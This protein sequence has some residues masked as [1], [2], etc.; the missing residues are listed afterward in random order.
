LKLYD[1]LNGVA[2]TSLDNFEIGGIYSD[3]RKPMGEGDIFIALK[4]AKFDA[5]DAVPELYKKGVSA[6]VV[7][8]D[9]GVPNQIIVDNSRL[10]LSR[11]WANYYGNPERKMK[12]I[13][14]TG[15]NGKTTTTTV[16]KKLLTALGHKCGLIGTCGNEIGD[17]P[18]HAERTTPE[19][20]EFFE[21]LAKMADAGCEYVVMEVSSQGLSQYRLGDAFFEAAV[22]TNLTQDHLDVHGTMENYYQAK[23]LLF[24]RCNKAL[25]NIDDSYGRRLLSEITC[26]KYSFSIDDYSADYSASGT[27]LESSGSDFWY[28]TPKKSFKAHIRLP[29]SYNVSN[30]LAALAT[31]D[32][33][34]YEGNI[35]VPA[36]ADVAGV[37]GRCEVVPTGRDFTV[38]LDYA[39]TPDALDNIL[40]AVRELTKGRLVCLFGCGGNRDP[41]KRPLMAKSAAHHADFLIVTSD[42]PRD[43]EPHSIITQIIA[44]LEGE[45]CEYT[46]I[47]DRREAIFW[48]IKNARPHDV[49]VLAGKGHEDY[50]I[51]AGGRKIHFDEREVVAEALKALE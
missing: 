30:C 47:D 25:V 38:I 46:E 12:L 43:E 18:V 16:I 21:L 23:K 27:Q 41:I 6:F 37:R 24:E 22:F 19:P 8:R 2:K 39:H 44:G 9:C 14:V 42:N 32:L 11:I 35:T 50:Q 5:H 45:T 10:A 33:L 17:T 20:D 15:T 1:I 28:S 48:A 3:N 4:G 36:I 7:E 13:G 26:E 29:G 40:S 34:G 51:L 31:L 49:I